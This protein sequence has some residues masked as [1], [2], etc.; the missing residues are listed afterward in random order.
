[1]SMSVTEN[2][3]L[4][5]KLKN[6][7]FGLGLGFSVPLIFAISRMLYK[8]NQTECSSLSSLASYT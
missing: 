8:W 4:N 6:L 1:M 3:S 7:Y 5:I 2:I